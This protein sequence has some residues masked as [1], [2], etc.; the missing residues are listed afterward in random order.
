MLYK[1]G[2]QGWG[3]KETGA[4]MKE[5]MPFQAVVDGQGLQWIHPKAYLGHPASKKM[6]PGCQ[7]S[8]LKSLSIDSANMFKSVCACVLYELA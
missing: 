1:G 7:R 5:P 4:P 2:S 6:G 8:D 3:I